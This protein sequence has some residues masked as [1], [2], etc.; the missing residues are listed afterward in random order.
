[1][2]NYYATTR[3]RYV[4]FRTVSKN[5]IMPFLLMHSTDDGLF[6][7]TNKETIGSGLKL[8]AYVAH[9]QNNK[10][11]LTSFADAILFKL[12]DKSIALTGTA[13]ESSSFV[14]SYAQLIESVTKQYESRGGKSTIKPPDPGNRP[15]QINPPATRID[16]TNAP[17]DRVGAL[18]RAKSELDALV[19]LPNV[20]KEVDNLMSFLQIQQERKRHG[21]REAAQSLHFVFTGNPGTGKT[22]VARIVGKLLFGFGILKTSKIVECDRSKLV[23]GYLGQSAI[24]T[25]E[26]VRSALDGVLFID[27]A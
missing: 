16:E 11:H 13:S 26:L 21:L 7:L 27:E 15:S 12:L 25:D 22:T 1:M 17:E 3:E 5:D 9:M 6:G 10:S 24:K 4:E 18:K 2:A 20:K 23:G 8:C 19:G 14:T